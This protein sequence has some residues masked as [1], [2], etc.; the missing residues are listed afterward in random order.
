MP[1]VIHT[2]VLLIIIP[3]LKEVKSSNI[4]H[5]VCLNAVLTDNVGAD[6]KGR[7]ILG[8]WS[9]GLDKTPKI[10]CKGFII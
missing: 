8:L 2:K 3:H 5:S 4:T 10:V 1:L 9:L 6:N 7:C